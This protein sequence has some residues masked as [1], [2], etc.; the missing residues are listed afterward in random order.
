M[1]LRRDMDAAE[2][3]KALSRLGYQ[4][5]RQTGSHMRL[6]CSDPMHSLTIPNHRPLRIGTLAAI[7]A[8]VAARRRVDKDTLVRQLWP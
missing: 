5:V 1:K 2:L 3:I 7:I 4:V 8:D 6:Q